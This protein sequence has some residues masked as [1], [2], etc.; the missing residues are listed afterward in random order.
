MLSDFAQETLDLA[1][2]MT[3]HRVEIGLHDGDWCEVFIGD[4]STVEIFNAPAR[5]TNLEAG[6]HTWRFGNVT[7]AIQAADAY[8]TVMFAIAEAA[9]ASRQTQEVA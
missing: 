5:D 7:A 2:S 4:Y 3:T 8:E 6:V 1:Q 9:K